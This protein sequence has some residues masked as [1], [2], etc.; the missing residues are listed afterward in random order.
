LAKWSVICRPKDQGELGINNLEVKNM[1][2]LGKR[3]FKLLI[4][5]EVWQTL[6]RRKHVGS[7][8][9]SYVI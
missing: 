1:T 2:L 5:E 9:L 8:T 3:L 4:E 7:M 6:L